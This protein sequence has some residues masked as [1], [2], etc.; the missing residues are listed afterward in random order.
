M[1]LEGGSTNQMLFL[2][3]AQGGDLALSLSFSVLSFQWERFG[4]E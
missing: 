4:A 1:S 3:Q 2:R